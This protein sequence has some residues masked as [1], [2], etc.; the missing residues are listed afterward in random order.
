MNEIDKAILTGFANGQNGQ[1]IARAVHLSYDAVHWRLR[2]LK[3]ALN[4][5]TLEQTI[6]NALRQ[7][8]IR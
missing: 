7:G 6:A 2:G 5:K 3:L 8:V 1:E 4:A